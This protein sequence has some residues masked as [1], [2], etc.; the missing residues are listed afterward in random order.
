MK[1]PSILLALVP[2]TVLVLLIVIGV[3]LFGEDLT[4]GP[5]QIALIT[6][7]V[8]AA[9]ICLLY[10]KIPWEKIEEGMMDNMSKTTSALFIVLMIG[11]LTASWTLSGV[12]PSIVY[13]G[14]KII[15]PSV[16]L[17]VV[18][19]FTG[20]IST[21]IGSSWTTVGTIGVAM[22]SAGHIMGFDSGWLA[23]AILSGAYFGDKVS[24]LS[25]TTNLSASIA[26]VNLYEHVKYVLITNVPTFVLTAIFFGV[27]GILIPNN[28]NLDVAAQCESLA[29]NFNISLWLFLIPG[30]TIFLMYKKISPYITLF[31]SAL[32]G[33]FVAV[34]AQPQIIAQISPYDVNS[35]QTLM[36]A[37]LKLL[38]SPVEIATGDPL[39]DDL[40]STNGMY[41]ML[42]TV[43]LVMCVSAFGAVMEV[44]G[45]IEVITVKLSK[46]IK[47]CV[48]LV[49]TTATTCVVCNLVLSDQYMSIIIPGKMFSKMY[50]DNGYEGKLLS[51]TLQDSAA[52]TSV[53][54]P[55]NSCG[56]VQS[57]VLG[58]PTLVYAPYC[59]FCYISPII[60]VIIAAT[61]YKIVHKISGKKEVEK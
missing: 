41:G 51:R 22:L 4:S 3:Y 29:S 16:F 59:F 61:G 12:V 34:F 33:A 9:L 54:I 38:S 21:M 5:S 37:P 2:I 60:S 24:P 1:K 28:D 32:L 19:I 8:V 39:I 13:Y 23:G 20:L 49:A 18:F 43:W 35:L 17:V 50:E 31:C 36:Y 27:A 45:F 30:V 56:V 44:G 15:D 46:L 26:R 6:G 10:L 7:S 53:L 14:L 55:W 52:V 11:A 58:I 25:D 42:N 48:S 47:S 40:A 57:S